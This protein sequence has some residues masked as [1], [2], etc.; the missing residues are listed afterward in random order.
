MLNYYNWDGMG[1]EKHLFLGEGGVYVRTKFLLC[2]MFHET[3]LYVNQ[4][5][6]EGSSEIYAGSEELYYF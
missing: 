6:S 2:I 1:S 4:G 3:S 5:Y